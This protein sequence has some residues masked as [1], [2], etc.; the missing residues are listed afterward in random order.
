MAFFHSTEFF[1]LLFFVAAAVV[2]LCARP[3]RRG[4]AQT[5]LVSGW[6]T[7]GFADV[8]GPTIEV[9]CLESG[10]VQITRT[11]LEDV[12]LTGAAS[13]AITQIGFDLSIIER[14]VAG[15]G[16]AQNEAVFVL[17][18]MGNEWY[19]IKYVCEHTGRFT[20]FSLHVRPGLRMV[21]PL[22]M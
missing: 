15:S 5:H 3:S 22:N 11:G 18:F 7:E 14:T 4:E 13:L 1:V 20:A 8:S 6:L 12:H 16:P 19:H 21:Q 17:N 2:G 9:E 10:N